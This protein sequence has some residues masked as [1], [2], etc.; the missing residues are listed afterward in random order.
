MKTAIA[1]LEVFAHREGEA[2]RRLSLVVGTPAPT[3]KD[4]AWSCRVALANLHRAEQIEARDSVEVLALAIARGREWLL[5]LE[6]D[7][8]TLFRDRA[9]QLPY[10]VV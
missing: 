10:D 9:G 7:G 3:G 2:V 8:F 1:S 5:A 4:G 6:A